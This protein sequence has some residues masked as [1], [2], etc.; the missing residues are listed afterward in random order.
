MKR[1]RITGVAHI[2]FYARDIER[3]RT[4]YTGLLGFQEPYSVKNPDGSLSVAFF[5]INDRQYVELLPETQA[6]TDTQRTW[7][8]RS[9]STAAGRMQIR[10]RA[11]RVRSSSGRTSSSQKRLLIH[12]AM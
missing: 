11:W 2:A 5:K 10:K 3:S 1:P 12:D 4:F 8:R 7:R 9:C 6:N